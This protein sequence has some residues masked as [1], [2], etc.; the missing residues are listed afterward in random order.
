MS[1]DQKVSYNLVEA[2]KKGILPKEMEEMLCGPICHA[3]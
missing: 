3:R 2:V 1:T